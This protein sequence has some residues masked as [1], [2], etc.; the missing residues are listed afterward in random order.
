MFCLGSDPGR[1]CPIAEILPRVEA[2]D[3]VPEAVNPR[4][5]TAGIPEPP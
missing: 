5:L 2:I 3:L 1:F 4:D